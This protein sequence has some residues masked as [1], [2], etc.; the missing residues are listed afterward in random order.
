METSDL[1]QEIAAVRN[2]VGLWIRLDHTFIRFTGPDAASWLQSQ[3][4]NDVEA[5]QS[6]E[7]HANALLDRQGRLQAN[8]TLHRWEDEYWALIETSQ[9]SAFIE[10]LEAHRFI[11]DVQVE[12]TGGELEQ[13]VLQ[14]PKTLPYLS[15]RLDRDTSTPIE[16]FPRALHACQ[17]VD[18][19][20]T[21]V[22][23]FRASTSGEDGYVFIVEKGCG[24]ALYENL[25]SD[26]RGFT[27]LPVSEDAREILRVEAGIPIFGRDMDPSNPIPETPLDPECVNMDKGCYLGQEIVARLHAYGSV[28]RA[29]MGILFDPDTT[30]ALPFNSGILVDGRRIGTVKSAVLSPT[31][32][33]FIAMAYLDRDHR[34]PE[35]EVKFTI[36]NNDTVWSGR[37]TR[38]PF[39]APS[40]R[41][42]RAR[43]LYDNALTLF[44]QDLQDEDASAIPLL[45]EAILFDPDFE[46]AYEVLGVILHRHHRVDE[47]IYYMQRLGEMNPDCLM[48]H[49]NLSVFYLAKGMIEEAEI[50]KAKAAVLQIQKASD[51]HQAR[52]LAEEERARI[53]REALE[54]IEMFREVLELDPDDP[55]ATFGLGK[56]Y[57]QLNQHE[58]ALPHLRHA[59]EVKKDYSAAFLDLGKCLEFLQRDEEAVTIYKEGIATASRKGDLMPMREMERR[60]N[61]LDAHQSQTT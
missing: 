8:F 36:A 20:G 15:A 7:G 38:L 26:T 32:N 40:T 25:L 57:I 18:L 31:L 49:T 58:D 42:E 2:E 55:M 16:H 11:E 17:P 6:G 45:Q 52:Q 5:L 3:T 41:E 27:V 22:L 46:D 19:F 35:E 43:S 1:R 47:A 34:T 10:R 23:A 53:Q 9:A 33:A 39:L 29:L 14:G 24:S 56:A 30:E 61:A 4:T 60:L 51:E 54:R 21:E 48:A 44:E 28:K 59:C 37:I 12:E 13:I 50:E